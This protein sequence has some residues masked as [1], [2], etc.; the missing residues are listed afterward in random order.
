MPE[1]LFTSQTPTGTNNSDGAPGITTATTE[2][3][4][5]AGQITHVRFYATTTT[6]GTYTGAVWQVTSGDPPGGGTLLAS[7]AS[8]GPFTGGAWN[9]ITLDTPVDVVPGV[10]YRIGLHNSDG[11]YVNTGSFFG[12]ALANGN[13][14]A[15]ANGDNPVGIGTLAQG[16]F[17]IDA[18]LTYP[19]VSF[20]ANCYFVDVVFTADG[21][22][23]SEGSA[24]VGLD[25]TPAAVGAAA[26]AGVAALG[27][28]LAVAATGSAPAVAPAQGVVAITF[29]LAPAAVGARGAAGVAALGLGLAVATTGVGEAGSGPGPWLTTLSRTTRIVTRTQAAS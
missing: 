6:G 27:L 2:M 19:I 26:H 14:T 10:L 4:A 12:S 28:A 11:R 15:P 16:T 22:D 20:N 21:D 13:I 7:K 18:A 25:L 1:S 5:V 3:Y 17:G 24:A 9:T 8:T 29:D 23:P